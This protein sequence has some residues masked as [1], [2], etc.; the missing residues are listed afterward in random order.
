MLSP[1]VHWRLPVKMS[2]RKKR[3]VSTKYILF[4][5]LGLNVVMLAQIYHRLL[6]ANSKRL[7]DLRDRNMLV[8]RESSVLSIPA[9]GKS[10]T[11]AAAQMRK[12]EARRKEI[13]M[14]RQQQRKAMRRPRPNY[15]TIPFVSEDEFQHNY[16]SRYHGL[17]PSI[18]QETPDDVCGDSPDFFPFFQL[19]KTERSRFSED[20]IIYGLFKNTTLPRRGET[21]PLPRGA[22]VELGAFNGRDESNTMFFDRCLGWKGLLI[23]AQ[24]QSYQQVIE[25]RPHAI[26][27]SFSP[28]CHEEGETAKIYDYPLSN[29]GMEDLAKSYTGKETVEIPCGPLGPVLQDVF[30]TDGIAFFSLDV[31]GAELLVLETIDFDVVNIEVLMVE[32]QNSYC[33]EADCPNVHSIRQVRQCPRPATCRLISFRCTILSHM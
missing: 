19:P 6:G 23:E 32:I 18:N 29:N 5:A 30:G 12:Y 14:M 15:T 33:P 27:M 31:E 16:A 11:V 13:A 24:A 9:E 4:V 21:L 28:T 3:K 8:S 10:E 22:Y 1:N 20:Y 2:S 25:N 17:L 7:E 26:K